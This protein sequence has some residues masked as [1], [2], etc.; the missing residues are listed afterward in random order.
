MGGWARR[1][2]QSW[3][4]N[5]IVKG[6]PGPASSCAKPRPSAGVTPSISNNPGDVT[7][8]EALPVP[9]K[10]ALGEEIGQIYADFHTEQGVDLRVGAGIQALRGRRRVE[11]VVTA[12]GEAIPCDFVVVGIGVV[13][14]TSWLAGSGIE[15]DNGVVVDEYCETNVPGTF[16]AGDVANWWHPTLQERLRVEHFDN[17]QNQGVAAAQ[18][19]IGQRTAYAPT[20]YFWSDQYDLNLQY[21]GHAS[22]WNR[23][24]LRGSVPEHSFTAFYLVG[25]QIRAALGVNRFK[26]IAAARRLIQARAPVTAEQLADDKVNLKQLLPG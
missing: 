15:I 14:E 11:E 9:L 5:T 16:A 2:V 18:N 3:G 26:D 25:S 21:V 24:V 4:A 20:P 7:M 8:I 12:S 19:M 22:H 13:P 23:V 6:F 17:A 1:V 10:R